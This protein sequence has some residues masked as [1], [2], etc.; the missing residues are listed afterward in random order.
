MLNLRS[1]LKYSFRLLLI[2]VLSTSA[3]EA[4]SAKTIYQSNSFIDSNALD[5]FDNLYKREDYKNYLLATEYVQ[6]SQYNYTTY[7]YM[8]LTNDKIDT[9]NSLNVSSNCEKMYVYYRQNNIYNLESYNDNE[10][11]V[12]NSVYYSTSKTI[13]HVEKMLILLNVGLFTFFLT[14]VLFKLFGG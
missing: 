13:N 6:I 1:I 2:V 10:L 11:N 3:A 7:Y 4:A 8:C 14:F 5:Y 9:S 12:Q